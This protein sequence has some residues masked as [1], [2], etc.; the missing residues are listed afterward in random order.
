MISEPELE[1]EPTEGPR[2]DGTKG[3]I[4]YGGRPGSVPYEGPE[5]PGSVPYAGEGDRDADGPG[6]DG[7]EA[8]T[9]AGEEPVPGVLARPRPP[10]QWALAGALAASVL[11]AGG[12]GAYHYLS[13]PDLR[14][15]RAT[16]NLCDSARLSAL[17]RTLGP[18]V[19]PHGGADE[20]D[21]A[22]RSLCRVQLVRPSSPTGGKVSSP[23]IVEILYTLHKKTDPAPEF[24]QMSADLQP[25]GYEPVTS[26]PVPGLGDR[27]LMVT[28]PS[29]VSPSL[30]VLDGGVVL[31]IGVYEGSSNMIDPLTGEYQRTE[32]LDLSDIK[33][34]LVDDMR[35]LMVA[36]KSDDGR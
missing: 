17:T 12:V 31:S 1:G 26:T 5:R 10:W 24:D 25:E 33:G 15:Y 20:S 4:R 19:L 34:D 3:R 16:S 27:A 2:E 11:W 32:P 35:D 14:G 18:K 36:L 29:Y 22:D 30:S 13:G 23:A 28:S 9:L 7:P 8:E 21:A 6:A